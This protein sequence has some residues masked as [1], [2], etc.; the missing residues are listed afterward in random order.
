MKIH[1]LKI[2][3]KYFDAIM[4]GEKK[5]EIRYDDRNYK[6]GDFVT[7]DKDDY[8]THFLITHIERFPVGIKE[9]Y[10]VLSISMNRNE[11]NLKQIIKDILWMAIRYAHGRHTMAPLS[12]RL[13][14]DSLKKMYPEEKFIK[15]DITIEPPKDKDIGGMS[16][17]KD[18]LDDLIPKE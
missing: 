10:V 15:K 9:G 18:Y 1:E 8:H 4:R 11:K 16:F 12:I 5:C 7:F 17:R 13:T 6:K 14:V 3:K 2:K